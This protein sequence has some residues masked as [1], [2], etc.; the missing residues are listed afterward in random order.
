MS[1]DNFV[2]AVYTTD[3]DVEE[4]VILLEKSGFNT[5]KL[6]IVAK[7]D[8]TEERA[9]GYYI[10]GG[11]MKYWG[12]RAPFWGRVWGLLVGAAFFAV[13]GVGPVLVAGPLVS[14]IVGTFECTVIAGGL[15]TVGAGLYRI[16]I[17]HNSV[18]Q[19]EA[20]LKANK[21]VL[22]AYGMTHEV[23]GALDIIQTTR[24]T[25]LA[26]HSDVRLERAGTRQA[27]TLKTRSISRRD[28][29]KSGPAQ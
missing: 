6:S 24:F 21:F 10:T 23:A 18:L 8:Q 11:R 2:V 5:K 26:V 17:P 15:T 28:L 7:D 22:V 19:Y 9:V 25:N 20:A 29:E 16:G 3:T 1:D 27:Y 4:V 12:K 13:P 14:W